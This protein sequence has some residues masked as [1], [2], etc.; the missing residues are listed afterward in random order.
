MTHRFNDRLSGNLAYNIFQY[1][2]NQFEDS[3]DYI[4]HGLIADISMSF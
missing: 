1:D 2:D 3:Q 4:A